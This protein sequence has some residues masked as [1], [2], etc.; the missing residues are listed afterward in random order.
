MNAEIQNPID[1]LV[2]SQSYRR[3]GH[4]IVVGSLQKK[5]SVP[6]YC[7]R[8]VADCGAELTMPFGEVYQKA[9]LVVAY[10]SAA[11]GMPSSLGG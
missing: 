11:A 6:C 1:R 4:S 10:I 7:L 5:R 3:D 9:T 2:F 8:T